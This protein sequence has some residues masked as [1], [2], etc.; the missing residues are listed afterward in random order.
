MAGWVIAE[1]VGSGGMGGMGHGGFA[2]RDISKLTEYV[3]KPDTKISRV[4]RK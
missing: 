2:T 4:Y 1:C 3:T